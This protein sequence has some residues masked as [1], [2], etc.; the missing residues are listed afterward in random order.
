[1][2][3]ERP[4]VNYRFSRPGAG[5]GLRGTKLLMRVGPENQRRLQAQLAA[6]RQALVAAKKP[7]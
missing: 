5:A 1:M 6:F 3:S 7:R 4:W 2:A